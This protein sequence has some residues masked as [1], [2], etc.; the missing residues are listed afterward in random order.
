MPSIIKYYI[1]KLIYKEK[2]EYIPADR[3]LFGFFSCL[4]IH[5]CRS[6]PRSIWNKQIEWRKENGTTS[7]KKKEKR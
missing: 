4:K 1:T 7:K 5:G 6:P 2:A 3:D